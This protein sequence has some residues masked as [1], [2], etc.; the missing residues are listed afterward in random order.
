VCKV[1]RQLFFFTFVVFGTAAAVAQEGRVI[2]GGCT[3][4]LVGAF[5]RGVQHRLP[6]FRNQ[7]DSSKVYRQM[8]ILLSFKDVD[9]RA[10]DP[11]A[12]YDSLLNVEGFNRRK[13]KGCLAEY[14][15]D[16]SNG[17]CN[18][19]FDVYGPIKVD[20]VACPYVNPDKDTRNY[21]RAQFIAAT[22][23]VLKENPDVDYKQYDWNG[24]GR[25][26]QVIYIYAGY[27][28][29]QGEGSYGYIWPNTSSFSSVKTPG[30]LTISNYSASGE[31]WINNSSCGI[32]TIAH[33][34]SH[35]FGLPDI[36]PTS[37]SAGYSVVDEWDLM[38]GGNFTNFGWCP[39]NYTPIEK[40][41]LGWLDFVDLEEPTSVRGLKPSSEGG[42][43]YRI[44]HS[45]S[46]WLLLENRQ[47]RGWDYGAPGR[48]LVI[49]HVFYDRS[50]WSGN[51]V[52]NNSDKRRFEL[53]HADN[54][55]YD[56]WYDLAVSRRVKYAVSGR[57]NN[58][59]LS[60]SPYPWSTDSTDF[61]NDQLTE[62]SVP[63]PKMNYPNEDDETQLGKPITN[64]CMTDDGL[65]SF[66]FMGGDT[67]AHI[68]IVCNTFGEAAYFDLRGRRLNQ[69]S[70]KGLIIVRSKDGIIKKV[71][72]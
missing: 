36:Y 37:S 46:E 47:Q 31:L 51:T 56:D 6:A 29:N 48:G 8:V 5:T 32:G 60:T 59:M 62:T 4:D 2:R 65:I 27:S 45:A 63:A 30:G 38:D 7:W 23:E 13:G 33:E 72:Y 22:E 14:F 1:I 50:V 17:R 58:T 57:L 55:D 70:G 19:H 61:I 3:P 39:T 53:I 35:C 28:G 71:M 67:D 10:D 34:F 44:K 25:I 20:T 52:N 43:V 40:Y 18:L 66:D 15:R 21:G 9:F 42:E 26:D 16:Q 11:R 24:D 49:Y 64:I 69:P 54:M 68:P 12:E 41:L